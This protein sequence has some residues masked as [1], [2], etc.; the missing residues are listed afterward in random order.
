[1]NFNYVQTGLV[2][3]FPQKSNNPVTFYPQLNHLP[4]NHLVSGSVFRE[5]APW[6]I[7]KT[8]VELL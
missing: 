2:N 7:F 3:C 4:G 8:N 1:M 6:S 5:C